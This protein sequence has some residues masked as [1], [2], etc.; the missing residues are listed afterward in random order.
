MQWLYYYHPGAVCPADCLVF[1]RHHDQWHLDCGGD[2]L[3]YRKAAD[4]A[5]SKRQK[6][7]KWQIPNAA[8]LHSSVYGFVV[9]VGMS[10][11]P[12][13]SEQARTIAQINPDEVIESF[14]EPI[15]KVQGWLEKNQIKIAGLTEEEIIPA[16]SSRFT[17]RGTGTGAGI[18]PETLTQT[19]TQP[20]GPAH[21][22]RP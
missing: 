17:S 16:I 21:T 11:I 7:K 1:Q 20:G 18:A 19:L 4:E 5:S 22:D 12:V 8:L 3:V 15:D 9:L 10:L 2:Y 13:V 6:I 14:Q